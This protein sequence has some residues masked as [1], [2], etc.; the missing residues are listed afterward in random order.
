MRSKH[1]PV[2][3]RYRQKN[4]GCQCEAPFL[5]QDSGLVCQ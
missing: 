2:N 4:C 1:K 5:R 3:T